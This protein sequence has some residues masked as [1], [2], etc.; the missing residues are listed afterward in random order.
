PGSGID[1]VTLQDG[2]HLLV[3][4]HVDKAGIATS[5]RSPLNVAVSRDG[6][7]W[8]AGLVLE[9]EKGEFSYP[10]VIQTKD[11][12][13]HIT[14]TWNRKKIRHVVIDPQ[15]LELQPLVP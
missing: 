11:G 10:A 8:Q 1:A 12:L 4:N 13:V 3:Y 5:A 15:K 7:T 9:N 14:Y 2:R 6:I